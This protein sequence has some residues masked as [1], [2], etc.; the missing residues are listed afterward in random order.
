VLGLAKPE[1]IYALLSAQISARSFRITA[2]VTAGSPTSKTSSIIG[3]TG[4]PGS[5]R[6]SSRWIDGGTLTALS[7]PPREAEQ[8][9]S[10]ALPPA[11]DNQEE[12]AQAEHELDGRARPDPSGSRPGQGRVDHET[13]A[14]LRFPDAA[15]DSE[16]LR[17]AG[18]HR[19]WVD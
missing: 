17:G 7:S 9:P 12:A 19:T 8:P 5:S 14:A 6:R 4:S 11:R 18:G 16:G 13:R 1:A 15:P 2:D 10:L 3:M